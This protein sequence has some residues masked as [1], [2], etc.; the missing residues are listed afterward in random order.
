MSRCID[1][2]ISFEQFCKIVQS[3]ENGLH[4]S[5]PDNLREVYDSRKN[6]KNRVSV[7]YAS[8]TG[9]AI[10]AQDSVFEW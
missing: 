8:L 1:G 6:I 9:K 4:Q 3:F 7:E 10:Q 2:G 5:N